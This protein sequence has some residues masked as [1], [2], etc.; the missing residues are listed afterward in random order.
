MRHQLESN[1]CSQFCRLTVNLSPMVP[2]RA[3][4]SIS[5]RLPRV[6]VVH[7]GATQLVVK[8]DGVEPPFILFQRLLYHL[9]YTSK[10]TTVRHWRTD[11]Y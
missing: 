7:S 9:A 6:S 3:I 4:L 10:F 5:L 8:C 1:Q 11:I 2:G